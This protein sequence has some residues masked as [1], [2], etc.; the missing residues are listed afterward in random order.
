MDSRFD[1]YEK[2][3]RSAAILTTSYVAGNVI[4][5]S[6]GEDT[7]LLNQ[8][9]LYVDFTIGSLTTAEIKIEFSKDNTNWYQSTSTSFSSGTGATSL[10]LYQLSATGKY[11]IALPTMDR[12]IRISAKG[13]GTVTGSSMAILALIG[14]S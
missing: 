3:I 7:Y 10:G 13:T 1:Y 12:Y 4:G 9:V 6:A 5:T 8:L 2:S 14:R 11:R